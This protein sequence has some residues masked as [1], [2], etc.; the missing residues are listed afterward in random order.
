MFGNNVRFKAQ[1]LAARKH[2]L[3][4]FAVG[5][6]GMGGG[7]CRVIGCAL[8]GFKFGIER[9]GGQRG[10][11]LKI[12]RQNLM[13]LLLNAHGGRIGSFGKRHNKKTASRQGR[14]VP[15]SRGS[16]FYSMVCGFCRQSEQSLAA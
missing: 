4:Q 16:S 10:V 2:C 15:A 13:A 1:P 9:G 8:H 6:A 7:K 14:A 12:D 11:C 5:E 3:L